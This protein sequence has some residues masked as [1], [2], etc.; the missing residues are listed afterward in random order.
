MITK[1]KN[2]A[3]NPVARGSIIV[4]GGIF[5][6]SIFSYLLQVCLGY[7]LPIEQFGTFNALLSL[8]VLL[9]IPAGAISTSLIKKTAD[10]LAVNDFYTLRKLFWSLSRISLELG[11]FIAL[12]FVVLNKSVS[13]YLNIPSGSI[14]YVFALFIALSFINIAP[15]SYLQGLLRFKAF[16]FVS[17]FSQFIRLIL[18]VLFVY[19]GFSVTG[20]FAGMSVTSVLT[21][22]ASVILLQKNF[23]M[24]VSP[25]KSVVNQNL[26][27]LYK[28]ILSFSIPVFF[29]NTG[30][31]ILSNIDIVMAKHYF[32]AYEAGVYS[33]VVTMAKV[34]LFGA[35]I[36]Q[37]VMFPQVSHLYSAGKNYLPRLLKFLTIQIL[38]IAV[39]AVVYIL[40]P[41]V[42][43]DLMFR[44]K[45]AESVKYLP[46][47]SV[48]I[49]LY[50]LLGFLS[51]FL[52]AINKTKAYWFILPACAVQYMFI[53][54]FHTGITDVIKAD[55]IASGLACLFMSVY[56]IK[57][58][59]EGLNNSSRLQTAENH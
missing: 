36:I 59:H 12:L 16:S 54:F 29:I 17:V 1:I 19:L 20:A 23:R 49:S 34:F 56:A 7:L 53:N 3:Q 31:T 14:V 45:F 46:M 18:P 9:A 35:G 13:Q 8:A 42:V 21:F 24:G 51:I 25:T 55:I 50:I 48:Y 47:F 39:G 6:G 5:A 15:N 38:I 11:V 27:E 33:G 26:T 4:T 57:S 43:N 30:I 10:L 40:V 2:I 41:S 37:V 22:I 52:L 28:Q 58:A 44:G 32:N